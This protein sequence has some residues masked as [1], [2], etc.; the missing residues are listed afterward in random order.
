MIC[1]KCNIEKG[2]AFTKNKSR[3]TGFSNICKDC[4]NK[5]DIDHIIPISL[6]KNENELIKLFHYQNLQPL[7]SFINRYVKKDKILIP[8]L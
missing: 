8:L 1:L 7:D 5:R 2:F 4:R 6:A 3:P